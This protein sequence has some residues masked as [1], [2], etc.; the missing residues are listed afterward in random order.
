MTIW[1]DSAMITWAEINL[2]FSHIQI[3]SLQKYV[4]SSIESFQFKLLRKLVIARKVILLF[5]SFLSQIHC[6][7]TTVRVT[8]C[9]F[10]Q[11]KPVIYHNNNFS[12]TWWG[13]NVHKWIFHK[14]SSVLSERQ[15]TLNAQLKQKAT[16]CLVRNG[17]YKCTQLHT[18]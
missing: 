17:T 10:L 1:H 11:K 9:F 15:K 6:Q 16:C 14:A 7:I 3:P 5:H 4:Q 8:I 18:Q 2:I 13:F 12:S